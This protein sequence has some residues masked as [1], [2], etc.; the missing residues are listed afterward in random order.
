MQVM[1]RKWTELYVVIQIANERHVMEQISC[2][3]CHQS[4]NIDLSMHEW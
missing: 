2:Q 4:P 1:E 3:L